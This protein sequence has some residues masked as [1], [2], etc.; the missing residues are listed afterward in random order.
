MVSYA[1]TTKQTRGHNVSPQ[2]LARIKRRLA[3]LPKGSVIDG[4]GRCVKLGDGRIRTRAERLKERTAGTTTSS[5][6]IRLEA[7]RCLARV[8]KFQAAHPTIHERI[9][10]VKARVAAQFSYEDGE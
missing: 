10:Q 6:A 3:E 8:A 2:K 4:N 7:A 1:S 5:H 9:A